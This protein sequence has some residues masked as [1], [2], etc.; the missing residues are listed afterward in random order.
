MITPKKKNPG[1]I[2]LQAGS[3]RRKSRR[4]ISEEKGEATISPEGGAGAKRQ[5]RSSNKTTSAKV[6]RVLWDL[7]EDVEDDVGA[8]KRSRLEEAIAEDER[9]SDGFAESPSRRFSFAAEDLTMAGALDP[10]VEDTPKE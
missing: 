7:D 1:Q 9:S 4:K 2:A 10:P 3:S 8:R 5:T 6:K